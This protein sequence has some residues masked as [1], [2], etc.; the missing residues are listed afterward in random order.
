MK[1]LDDAARLCRKHRSDLMDMRTKEGIGGF[2]GIEER[3]NHILEKVEKDFGDKS[4]PALRNMLY[5]GYIGGV[6]MMMD[7]IKELQEGSPLFNQRILIMQAIQAELSLSLM[8]QEIDAMYNIL[9]MRD[10]E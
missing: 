1:A 6:S 7:V 8:E 10:E 5:T 3:F 2:P 9:R 4:P